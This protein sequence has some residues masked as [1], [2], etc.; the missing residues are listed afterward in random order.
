MKFIRD[1]IAE[2]SESKPPDARPQD[3]MPVEQ[4]EPAR[5]DRTITRLSDSALM[6]GDA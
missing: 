5:P 1:I 2:R 4:P 6:D 3:R